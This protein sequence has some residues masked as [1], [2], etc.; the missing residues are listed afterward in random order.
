MTPIALAQ[1]HARCFTH[2][3]PWSAEEFT[4]LADD[5]TF[6]LHHV[7]G[8]FIVGRTAAGSSELLT[9][10]VSPERRRQGL[11]RFLVHTYE[12]E[13]AARG[14]RESYLDVSVETH[15]AR[16]LYEYL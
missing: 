16:T 3:R 8:G 4:K 13:A 6:H 1:L 11:G 15:A 7:D 9:L 5:A 10:V 14:G 2:P 12:A